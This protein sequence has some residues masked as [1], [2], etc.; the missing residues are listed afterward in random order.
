M[1]TPRTTIYW[2]IMD[3]PGEFKDFFWNVDREN[4]RVWFDLGDTDE[5][6]DNVTKVLYLHGSLHLCK[7]PEG[8]FKRMSSE[9]GNILEQFDVQ[10]EAIPLFI[11]EGR[12]R[13]KLA[14]IIRN[15]YLSF[16]YEKF[17]KHRGSLVVFGHSLTE[18]FDQ[19]LI[20][21]MRKWR[22]YDQKRLRGRTI[23]RVIAV[24]MVPWKDGYDI[25]LEKTRLRRELGEY[26]ELHFFNSETHPLGNPLLSL[27]EEPPDE[28]VTV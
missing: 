12:H 28:E 22:R 17:S 26:Y 21:A 7:H 24:S 6:R 9:S 10:G 11:S 1:F 23:R 27:H 4:D 5:W 8:T 18:Q 25:V 16:S 3:Q 20:D 14:A 15:D 19:H 2:S 13:D